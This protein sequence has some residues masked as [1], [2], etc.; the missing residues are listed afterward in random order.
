MS[1][2]NLQVSRS[3]SIET[4]HREALSAPRW[5]PLTGMAMVCAAMANSRPHG[6]PLQAVAASRQ[7][8]L[9]TPMDGCYRNP[10]QILTGQGYL[11]TG[12]TQKP[13][14]SWV[15]LLRGPSNWRIV[16][17]LKP[18]IGSLDL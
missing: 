14:I 15:S 3:V 6:S 18:D 5:G 9:T 16:T 1:Q 10:L 7:A 17:A 12:Y 13:V 11:K 4:H 2:A 8:P